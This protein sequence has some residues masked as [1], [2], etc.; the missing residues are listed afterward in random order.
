[1]API[2]IEKKI[3]YLALGTKSHRLITYKSTAFS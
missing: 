2:R 1:M 3:G